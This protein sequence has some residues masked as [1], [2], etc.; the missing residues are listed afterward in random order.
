MVGVHAGAGGPN[1][2]AVNQAVF[3]LVRSL[4]R[5]LSTERHNK[6]KDRSVRLSTLIQ[7]LPC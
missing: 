6:Q 7:G 4:M 3:R 1:A 5:D 2:R